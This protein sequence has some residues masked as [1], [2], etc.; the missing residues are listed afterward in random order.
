MNKEIACFF[1][2]NESDNVATATDDISPGFIPL[3]GCQSGT[4][5]VMEPIARGFK[6]AIDDINAGSLIIK[7]GVPIGKAKQDISRGCCVHIHNMESLMDVRSSHFSS[8]DAA[9]QD[10]CYRLDD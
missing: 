5:E 2:I 4:I 1:I 10:M 6:V 9:P 3:F 8:V 7:Y